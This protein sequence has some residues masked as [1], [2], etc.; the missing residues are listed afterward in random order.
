M[1][2][3]N[4]IYQR[5]VVYLNSDDFKKEIEGTLMILE[6]RANRINQ[7]VRFMYRGR[8]EFLVITM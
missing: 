2:K 5:T 3:G 7:D 4:G 8:F 1:V 6:S